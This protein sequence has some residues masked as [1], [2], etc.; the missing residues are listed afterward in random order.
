MAYLIDPAVLEQII[1]NLINEKYPNRPTSDFASL[2]KEAILALDHQILK[3]VLGSLTK[4]QGQELNTLLDQDDSDPDAFAKFF[5]DR[6]IDLQKILA[7]TMATFKS[8]FLE[9]SENA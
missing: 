2:K 8:N 9:G 5:T 3:D 7:N 4:E 6:G 1:D